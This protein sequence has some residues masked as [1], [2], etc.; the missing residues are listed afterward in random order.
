MLLTHSD[1]QIQHEVP[2]QLA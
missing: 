1:S 2:K